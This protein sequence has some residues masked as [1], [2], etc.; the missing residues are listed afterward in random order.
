M[1]IFQYIEKKRNSC[2]IIFLS[3]V[4][5]LNSRILNIDKSKYLDLSDAASFDIIEKSKYI[6]NKKPGTTSLLTFW[7]VA[8]FE[9]ESGRN[10]L[11]NALEYLVIFFLRTFELYW[12]SLY[13]ISA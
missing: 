10:L 9:T 7:V 4:C 12:Y 13:L 11:K 5:R 3:F 8:D 2:R 6:T 1:C